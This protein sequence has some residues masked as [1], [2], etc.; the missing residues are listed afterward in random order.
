MQ[1]FFPSPGARQRQRGHVLVGMMAA[2]MVA[3]TVALVVLA[4]LEVKE[5]ER[6]R[7]IDEQMEECLK[8]GRGAG[9]QDG[10]VTCY[11]VV[12]R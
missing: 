11:P 12:T 3:F 6:R 2:A 9:L 1:P 10:V 8:A 7:A 5:R 4:D